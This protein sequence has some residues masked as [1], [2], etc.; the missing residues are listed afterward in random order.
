[1][2]FLKN[3][4]DQCSFETIYTMLPGRAVNVKIDT[5]LQDGY[6]VSKPS[7]TLGED[8]LTWTIMGANE[9]LMSC[10]GWLMVS[11]SSTTSCRDL[12][13]SKILSI[14]LWTS[15]TRRQR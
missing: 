5:V 8:T 13:S 11:A 12:A 1:M 2:V 15:A 10:P 7:L 6:L 9:V 4:W 14:S 3:I